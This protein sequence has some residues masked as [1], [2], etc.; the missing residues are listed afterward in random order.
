MKDY[1]RKRVLDICNHILESKHT[2]RQAATVFGVSKS[3][4]HKDM[5]ERL[6]TINKR[7][8]QRVRHVLELNKAER[9]I[10]GGE[11]TRKKYKD[12]KENEEE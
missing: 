11:A 10:R 7:L 2:V 5:I 3:T 12:T 4:V 1:I 9:H 6:P 8:A